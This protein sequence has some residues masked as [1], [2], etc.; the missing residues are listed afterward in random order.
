MNNQKLQSELSSIVNELVNAKGR[1]QAEIPTAEAR[2]SE[3][4]PVSKDLIRAH[5]RFKKLLVDL[6]LIVPDTRST[7]EIG[8]PVDLKIDP[9]RILVVTCRNVLKEKLD[10]FQD[11]ILDQVTTG[12]PLEARYFKEINPNLPDAA[13]VN[14]EKKIE[15]VFNQLLKKAQDKDYIILLG[16][17]D[18]KTDQLLFKSTELVAS[19]S[20]KRVLVVEVDSMQRLS[21]SEVKRLIARAIPSP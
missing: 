20:G 1:L 17:T 16:I 3:R 8:V 2:I 13:M 5:E 12:G 21:E 11:L 15:K 18:D 14:I 9:G 6:D 4:D 10:E 19:R 7:V